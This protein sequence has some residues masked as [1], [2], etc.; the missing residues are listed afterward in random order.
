MSRTTK[1]SKA[2]APDAISA[3]ASPARTEYFMRQPKTQLENKRLMS[4]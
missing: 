4:L 3:E 2:A 1:G